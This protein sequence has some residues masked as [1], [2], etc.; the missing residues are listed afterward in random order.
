MD[1]DWKGWIIIDAHKG[2]RNFPKCLDDN[3]ELS[4]LV[5]EEYYNLYW[6]KAK[7]DKIKSN[8]IAFHLFDSSVNNGVITAVKMMQEGIGLV[9]DG[10]MGEKTLSRLNSLT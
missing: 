8:S 10:I 4:G 5:H 1:K 6:L 2:A 3:E 9:N 7:C